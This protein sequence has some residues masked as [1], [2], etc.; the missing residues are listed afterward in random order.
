MACAVYVAFG[1]GRDSITV[2]IRPDGTELQVETHHFGKRIESFEVLPG[3]Q[4]LCVTFLETTA[5]QVQELGLY[6]VRSHRM[7]WLAEVDFAED[8]YAISSRGV[9]LQSGKKT[10]LLD[11]E[12][13]AV[14]EG[15]FA[16]IY[17]DEEHGIVLGAKKL[18][19]DDLVGISLGDGKQRWKGSLKHWNGLNEVLHTKDGRLLIS[20]DQFCALDPL[21]GE[22]RTL[23]FKSA[24]VKKD[25]AYRKRKF[26]AFMMGTMFGAVAAGT[27][28]GSQAKKAGGNI[29][30]GAHP[31]QDMLHSLSSNI[32]AD[33]E[34]IYLADRKNLW[35]LDGQLTEVW[36]TELPEKASM[37]RLWIHADTLF[38]E[39]YGVGINYS[40]QEVEDT[41]PYVAMFDMR[42]G[43]LM[44]SGE[45]TPFSPTKALVFLK[46]AGRDVFVP[47][48]IAIDEMEAADQDSAYTIAARLGENLYCIHRGYEYWVVDREGGIKLKIPLSVLQMDVVGSVFV[49][50]TAGNVI[51]QFDVS[52]L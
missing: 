2:G 27:Y 16:P 52:Q 47:A 41:K 3:K 17:V 14:W 21:T 9:I 18:S 28:G 34:H 37:S 15:K 4:Q 1:A 33:G 26:N 19:S 43:S 8:S 29:W 31:V 42:N 22:M 49:G 25:A 12:G 6:D 51:F 38:Y 32:L 50:L 7:K 20:S 45:D 44:Q 13:Q 23:D 48:E 11:E 24:Y 35:C 40:G 46:E 36:K 30:T 39:N 10:V 5:P